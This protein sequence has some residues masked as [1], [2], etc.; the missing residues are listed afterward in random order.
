M[1]GL[2]GAH[3]VFA[4][5]YISKGSCPLIISTEGFIYRLDGSLYFRFFIFFQMFAGRS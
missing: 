4:R 3:V 2:A 1:N 5:N